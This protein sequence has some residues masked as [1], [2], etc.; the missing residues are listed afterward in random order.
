MFSLY[1]TPPA[2]LHTI[3]DQLSLEIMCE[4]YETGT[5]NLKIVVVFF[6]S[7]GGY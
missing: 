4:M 3:A 1:L 6:I 7:P 5:L 2:E